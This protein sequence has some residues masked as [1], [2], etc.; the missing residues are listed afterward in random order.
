[1][2]LVGSPDL[3]IGVN[4]RKEFGASLALQKVDSGNRDGRPTGAF[5]LK[6]QGRT[7][8]KWQCSRQSCCL[9]GLKNDVTPTRGWPHSLFFAEQSQ[10][11]GCCAMWMR[12]MVKALAAQV[13][14]FGTWLCSSKSGFVW[15]VFSYRTRGAG[16]V[17]RPAGDFRSGFVRD[18]GTPA[19]PDSWSAQGH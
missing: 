2:R 1:M 5:A 10:L 7:N 11:S 18:L 8:I 16:C 9:T 14:Q 6:D 15:G 17:R 19:Q 4:P 12:L 3:G 13:R